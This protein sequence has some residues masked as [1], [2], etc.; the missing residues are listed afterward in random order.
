[1]GLG[2]FFSLFA[3][4]LKSELSLIIKSIQPPFSYAK[5]SCGETVYY[6][7]RFKTL[8]LVQ[9][10][11]GGADLSLRFVFDKSIAIHERVSTPAVDLVDV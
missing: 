4:L 11:A 3:G 6:I 9:Y 2:C 1:M 5:D 10:I 8:A 7:L